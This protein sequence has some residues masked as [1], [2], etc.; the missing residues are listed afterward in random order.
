MGMQHI[1]ASI[2]GTGENWNSKWEFENGVVEVTN[3]ANFFMTIVWS[4]WVVV[5]VSLVGY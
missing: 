2:G 5:T 4:V 1:D 3:F